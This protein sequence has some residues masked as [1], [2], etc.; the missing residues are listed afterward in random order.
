[1]PSRL[2]P[3]TFFALRT[4]QAT[5]PAGDVCKLTVHDLGILRL[6]SGRLGACD[7]F[8]L[9][10]DPAIEDVPPGSYPVR[11]TV[12]DVSEDQDAS[13][14]RE[15]YLSVVLREGEVASVEYARDPEGVVGG[16]SELGLVGVDAGTVAF[17]D[18]EAVP[19]CM[20]P[21]SNWYDD[22]FDS[23]ADDSWFARMDDEDDLR[24][25][26]ANIVMPRA[27]DGENVVLTHSGWGDGVY[28]LVFTRDAAG[29][30]LAV[31]IDLL[32]AG[33]VEDR[34]DQDEAVTPETTAE[35]SE[36]SEPEVDREFASD[37]SPSWWRRLR[38]R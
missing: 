32:V 6:P 8:V 20:P 15:A 26:S 1:M 12:A 10:D 23:G 5:Q 16:N 13:H 2:R 28:P 14:V 19:L 35:P 7:P 29:D 34:G 21:P 33:P 11:L 27:H 18:A 37:A 36:P 31:H 25:G 38:G 22:V 9:L 30:L 17:V 4:G 24:A 3:D